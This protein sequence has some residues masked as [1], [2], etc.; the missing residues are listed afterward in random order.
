MSAKKD[1][2]SAKELALAQLLRQDLAAANYTAQAVTAILGGAEAQQA[3]LTGNNAAAA[4][5]LQAAPSSALKSLT[6]LFQLS[7]CALLSEVE[8]ALPRLTVQGLA[9]LGAVEIIGDSVKALLALNPV[10]IADACSAKMLHWWLF[11]DLDDHLRQAAAHTEH[12][13]GVGGATRSLILQLNS[14]QLI[15][16]V[17]IGTGCGVVALHLA[18]RTTQVVATDISKR[19]LRLAT[20]NAALNNVQGIEFR[21]GSLF[22]PLAGETFELLVSNPPFVIEPETE[23]AY[24]YRSTDLRGD[25]LAAA[26][27]IGAPQVL[28]PNGEAICLINWENTWGK[29]FEMQP[30]SWISKAA[31]QMLSASTNLHLRAAWVLER[32]RLSPL[33]YAQMWVRDG[34]QNF[35]PAAAAAKTAAYLA[36]F[37]SRQTVSISLGVCRL[38]VAQQTAGIPNGEPIVRIAAERGAFGGVPANFTGATPIKNFAETAI[39]KTVDSLDA[40]HTASSLKIGSKLVKI[41]LELN[42]T[43]PG[44]CLWATFDSAIKIAEL[45][46][47]ELLDSCLLFATTVKEQRVYSP[48]A[49]DPEQIFLINTAPFFIQRECGTLTAAMLGACDGELTLLQL[50]TAL[51]DIFDVSAQAVAVELLAEVRELSWSGF[52]KLAEIKP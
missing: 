40:E 16:A 45:S 11:S 50:I 28:R 38:R 32:E 37:K 49:A 3:L 12:V 5:N 22:E 31:A 7:G 42:L 30:A 23:R 10:E 29:S 44:N 36:D 14:K 13:M 39:F 21:E 47:K 34:G 8:L 6:K 41:N 2:A 4:A 26:M 52:L 18:Q 9:A 51:A 48:G 25:S 24:T 17:D 35:N 15:N 19:A 1:F 33:A 20:I 27:V 43:Y 46:D